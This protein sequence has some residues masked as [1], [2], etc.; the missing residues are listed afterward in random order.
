MVM[1]LPHTSAVAADD[2]QGNTTSAGG[3]NS[4]DGVASENIGSSPSYNSP[5][6][7]ASQNTQAENPGYGSYSNPTNTD[8]TSPSYNDNNNNPLNDEVQAANIG[9]SKSSTP[10]SSSSTCKRRKKRLI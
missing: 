4:P 10:K 2:L 3:Y 6:G 7:V 8:S 5:D 1:G 9:S